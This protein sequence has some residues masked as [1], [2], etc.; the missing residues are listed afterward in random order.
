M[1]G[2]EHGGYAYGLWGLV[3]VN[4]ALFAGFL[5][6]FAK[7]QS[8]TDWR[9][10]G[11]FSAFLVA[12][13]VEMYGLPFSIYLLVSW[14]GSRYPVADPF[15]HENGHLWGVFLGVHT[16]HGTWAHLLSNVLIFGGAIIVAAGWKQVHEA[17]GKPVTTGLYAHIKHPQ[18]TG[19][20]AIIIGFLI[21][22]PTLITLA[23]APVLI[24]RYV[25]L[26][27][28]EERY[29]IATHG[30]PFARYASRTPMFLSRL[31]RWLR[32]SMKERA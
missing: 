30:E 28:R 14:L 10:L 8:K 32:E 24:A 12:M 19:F 18:Y 9:S 31:T 13:F 6:S 25:L 15:T 21:Q 23:M 20:I 3:L 17:N 2:A 5:F 29:M 7:P 16:G 27:R 1:H 22:W 4:I 11:V 26:A